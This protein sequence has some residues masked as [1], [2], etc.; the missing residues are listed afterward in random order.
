V[1]RE[2]PG[3]AQCQIHTLLVELEFVPTSSSPDSAARGWRSG[4]T[5]HG[6]EGH[7]CTLRGL[8]AGAYR[9]HAYRDRV[10]LPPLEFTLSEG[11]SLWLPWPIDW[12]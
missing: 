4:V 5:R 7:A 12:R 6:I 3:T 2:T 1:Q 11:E 8:A 9:L 10:V